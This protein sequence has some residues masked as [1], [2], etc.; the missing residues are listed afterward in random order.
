MAD[1]ILTE[2]EIEKEN[3]KTGLIHRW[4]G[5]RSRARNILVKSFN[6]RSEKKDPTWDEEFKACLFQSKIIDA[7]IVALDP[8]W[9]PNQSILVAPKDWPELRPDGWQDE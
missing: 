9:N 7:Q 4:M 5:L 3:L 8:S 1:R 2:A 6:S